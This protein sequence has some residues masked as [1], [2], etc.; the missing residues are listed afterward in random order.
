MWVNDI[1]IG[2]TDL[3]TTGH[4]IR[5]GVQVLLIAAALWIAGHLP[6]KRPV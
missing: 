6:R 2:E 5:A 3:S 1:T 4:L